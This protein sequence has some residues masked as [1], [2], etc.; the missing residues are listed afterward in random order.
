MRVKALKLATNLYYFVIFSL[1]TFFKIMQN[2]T[3]SRQDAGKNTPA[4]LPSMPQ[5]NLSGP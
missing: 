1:K 3:A 4:N 2:L 5:K